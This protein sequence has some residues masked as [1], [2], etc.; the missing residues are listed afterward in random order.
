MSVLDEIL[1]GALAHHQAGRLAEAESL[2]RQ[3]LALEP[4]HADALHLLGVLAIQVGRADV[5]ADLIEQA[6]TSAPKSAIYLANHAAALNLL[7]RHRQAEAQCRKAIRAEPDYPDAYVNLAKA[8]K[9]QGQLTEAARAYR[10]LL[11]RTPDDVASLVD[12]GNLLLDLGTLDEA[13]ERFEQ[14]LTLDPNSAGGHNGLGVA[15]LARKR[16]EEAEDRFL[17]AIRLAPDLAVAHSNLGLILRERNRLDDAE[18][19]CREA[20]LLKPEL[21]DAHD[22]LGLVLADKNEFAEA[23]AAYREALR[24]KPDFAQAHANL[25]ITL[26]EQGR[27]AESER[28]ARAALKLRPRMAQAHNSLAA[29]LYGQ[30]RIAE[31]DK[32][33]LAGPRA[34][35]VSPHARHDLALLLRE[36]GRPEE[37][38]PVAR[39]AIRLG[40]DLAE[41]HVNLA[42]LLLLTGRLEE[43]WREYEWRQRSWKSPLKVRNFLER[44]WTGERLDGKTL[45]VHAE[46]GMGD[47]IQFARYVPLIRGA[48]RVILDV[49]KPLIRLFSRLD[50]VDQISLMGESLPPFDLQ[51]PMLSLPLAFGT[52]LESIPANVPYLT[53]D[54]ELAAAWSKRLAALPGLKVGL[55]WRGNPAYLGDRLRSI[56]PE[57]LAPLREIPGVSF[58]SLQKREAG[59][60]LRAAPPDLAMVDW[61]E[62]L[63]DFEDTAALIAGLDLVIAVDTATAHLAGALGKP[64]W[65]LNRFAPDW[66]WLLDR[67]DSPWYPTLRQFRQTRPDD[68]E[69]ALARVR[70]ELMA[71]AT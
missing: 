44:Q 57:R 67:D 18:R 54:A 65:L 34:D 9:A 56:A 64:T 27:D 41:P 38:I 30:G 48:A 55:V 2:Y 21:P 5:A 6:L 40:P 66:R 50:G 10:D 62:E 11:R 32:Q 26:H 23:E 39:E 49:P 35:P 33:A 69:D 25:A 16:P 8:L 13:V 4:G 7:S 43:G 12:L 63:G 31:A 29:A 42:G 17:E 47:N 53:A 46:Q 24:L 61:T 14:A 22:N 15:L 45:L 71:L 68:W 3:I 60:K 20:V 1:A 36:W 37:A 52:G 58:V 51:C 28:S 19:H 70:A 59:G